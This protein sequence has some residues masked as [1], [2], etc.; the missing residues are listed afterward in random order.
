[1]INQ[2]VRAEMPAYKDII[3]HTWDGPDDPENPF[4]WGMKYKWLLTITVCFMYDN[5]TLPMQST[6]N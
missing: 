5:P 6:H 2:D 1:M 3:I 4:N